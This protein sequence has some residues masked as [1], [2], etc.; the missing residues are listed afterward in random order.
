MSP[1]FDQYVGI[2]YSG[3]QT[4]TSSLKGLRIYCA[5]RDFAPAEELPPPSPRK[6]WTRRG[7]AEWLGE[8]FQEHR[9]TLIRG[10][11][12][13]PRHLQV[14]TERVH[15]LHLS[16]CPAF[17][18]QQHRAGHQNAG[19]TCARGRHDVLRNSDDDRTKGVFDPSVRGHTDRCSWPR[20]EIR[21][22]RRHR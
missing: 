5:D 1:R 22:L 12:C 21:L 17:C 15:Q 2:D 7:V 9:R 4:P 10:D 16:G 19:A 3:A 20:P 11:P 6:Y 18:V 14:P 8:Q 13:D